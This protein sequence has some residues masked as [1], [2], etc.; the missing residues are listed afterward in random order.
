M[1]LA[2][3][4]FEVSCRLLSLVGTGVKELMLAFALALDEELAAEAGDAV[5]D[6]DDVDDNSAFQTINE[7]GVSGGQT[8]A[9]NQGEVSGNPDSAF[10]RGQGLHWKASSSALSKS[11]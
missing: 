7:S 4:L 5:L 11:Q 8:Q 3:K 2:C 6:G 9:I 10:H 1:L